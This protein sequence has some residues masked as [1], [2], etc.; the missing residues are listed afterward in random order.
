MLLLRFG[1][2]DKLPRQERFG[3]GEQRIEV[4]GY[5]R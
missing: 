2:I 3:I 1:E 4:V 5:E